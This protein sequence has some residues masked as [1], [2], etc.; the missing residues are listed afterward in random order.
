MGLDD[1]SV[2][3]ARNCGGGPAFGGSLLDA[4]PLPVLSALPCELMRRKERSFSR[5]VMRLELRFRNFQASVTGCSQP[6]IHSYADF[7]EG[8]FRRAAEC[9][10]GLQIRNISDPS[11]VAL[12]PEY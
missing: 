2:P 4:E 3:S 1:R 12:G 7:S 9:R 11:A 8:L 10:A 5:F 6:S